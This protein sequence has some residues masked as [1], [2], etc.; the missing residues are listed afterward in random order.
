MANI[1]TLFGFPFYKSKI[2]FKQS[3]IDNILRLPYQRYD[4][5]YV[6]QSSYVL[7]LPKFKNLSTYII[8]HSEIFFR[9][10]LRINEKTKFKLTTSW[11]V[12]HVTGDY[13]PNHMHQNA[14]FSGIVYLQTD[15]NSGV[16]SFAPPARSYL[17]SLIALEYDEENIYNSSKFSFVPKKYDIIIFPS[18]LYHQVSIC[19]SSQERLI[20]GFNF[21]PYGT[22]LNGISELSI[23]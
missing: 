16:I 5:G 13:A 6:S 20:I 10:Y 18:C 21:F 1:E 3:I 8:K 19:N 12:K 2:E 11:T 14:M 9:E 17:D 7:N 23:K 4:N 22:F 15:D